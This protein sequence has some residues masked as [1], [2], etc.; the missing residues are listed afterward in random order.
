MRHLHAVGR[1]EK[2]VASGVYQYSRRGAP[3]KLLEYWSV[4]EVG[5]AYFVRVDR[6]GRFFDG[7]ST[8][9]EALLNPQ[10]LIERLD[11]RAYGAGSDPVRQISGTTIFEHDD[12]QITRRIQPGNI[13]SEYQI[14]KPR[15]FLL[16][17]GSLYLDG[18]MLFALTEQIDRQS[19]PLMK[20]HDVVQRTDIDRPL[21]ASVSI[22]RIY[23]VALRISGQER[24]A[25]GYR[26]EGWQPT[27]ARC[28]LDAI[29]S[30]LVFE[31]EDGS[32]SAL[33][34][35]YARRAQA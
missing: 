28:Y 7:R 15:L 10:G 30:T 25:Q 2:F 6:D 5:G 19:L 13:Q 32:E 18:R 12:V 24:I 4:H 35:R 31:A 27:P 33:L 14:E 22:E 29:G 3:V 26:L 17:T 21:M 11:W 16:W 1:H 34:T 8:L 9:Y 23:D 20:L